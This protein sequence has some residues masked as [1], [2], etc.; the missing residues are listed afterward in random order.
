MYLLPLHP[1]PPF[2]R[3]PSPSLPNSEIPPVLEDALQ[4][5]LSQKKA[6]VTGP[7]C[8][9]QP[10][11]HKAVTVHMPVPLHLS[12]FTYLPP[13]PVMFLREEATLFLLTPVCS[14]T[15]LDTL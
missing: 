8:S 7:P 10:I 12:V 3:A 2:T 11:I 6:L 14:G 13:Q 5:S 4:A 1:A 15:M 9:A